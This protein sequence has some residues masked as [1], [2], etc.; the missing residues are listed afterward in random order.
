MPSRLIRQLRGE[1]HGDGSHR[2]IGRF[3]PLSNSQLLT[4]FTSQIIEMLDCCQPLEDVK[5]FG[6]TLAEFACLAKCNGLDATTKF[7]NAT[8]VFL[9]RRVLSTGTDM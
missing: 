5:Q 7:A 1:S 4:S 6:I 8:F 2:V 9:H 3:S